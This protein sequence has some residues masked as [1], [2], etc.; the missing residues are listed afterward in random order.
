MGR[1][2]GSALK[3]ELLSGIGIGPRHI[4]LVQGKKG[5]SK[6]FHSGFKSPAID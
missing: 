2:V 5:F 1:G 4:S 6:E 3:K